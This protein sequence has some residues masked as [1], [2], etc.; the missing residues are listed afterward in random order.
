LFLTLFGG[1]F[2]FFHQRFA[3]ENEIKNEMIYKQKKNKLNYKNKTYISNN[4]T[5]KNQF[6]IL[7]SKNP[8]RNCIE[9]FYFKNIQKTSNQKFLLF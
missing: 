8:I 1:V 3:G 4:Q 7:D 5:K 9:S 6:V 2:S